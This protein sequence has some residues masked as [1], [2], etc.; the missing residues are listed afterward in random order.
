[1]SR[2]E[3]MAVAAQGAGPLTNAQKTAL[4]VLARRAYEVQDRCGLVDRGET[5]DAWRRAAVADAAPGRAGLTKLTQ[6]DFRPV[7]DRLLRLAGANP[8][9]ASEADARMADEAARALWAL[10]RECGRV[11]A[12]FDDGS[13]GAFA[14]AAHIVRDQ[15]G[16]DPED[17]P[18]AALWRAVYTLRSRARKRAGGASGARDGGN[19]ARGAPRVFPRVSRAGKGHCGGRGDGL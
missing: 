6:A 15:A 1:M 11:A 7:R 19:P 3:E 4:A 5:F 12:A 17:A 2:R 9:Y 8:R 14:Y 18:A 16:V 10:R 13:E